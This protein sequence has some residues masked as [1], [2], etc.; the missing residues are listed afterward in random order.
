MLMFDNDEVWVDESKECASVLP[1]NKCKIAT[2]PLK[3]ANEMLVAKRMKELV[4][5]CGKLRLSDQTVS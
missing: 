5:A 1:P 2:L 4:D 3:D